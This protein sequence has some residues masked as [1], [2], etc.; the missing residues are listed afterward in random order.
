MVTVTLTAP[1]ARALLDAAGQGIDEWVAEDEND[2][3]HGHP[4][5]HAREIKTAMRGY[6]A[7]SRAMPKDA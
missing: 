3:A 7:L 4:L 6:A 1:Q 5:S 2:E